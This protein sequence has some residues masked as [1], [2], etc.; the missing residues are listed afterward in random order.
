MKKLGEFVFLLA[1]C[2]LLALAGCS[3]S[4]SSHSAPTVSG[5][6]STGAAID[7]TVTLKDATGEEV[8]PQD[9]EPDGSFSFDVSGLTVPFVIKATATDGTQNWY[10]YASDSGTGNVNPLTTLVLAMAVD[11][12]DPADAYTDPSVV[13]DDKCD[14]ALDNAQALFADLFSGFGVG[15]DFDPFTGDCTVNH[16]GIDALFD[17]LDITVAD[18]SL[19]ITNKVDEIRLIDNTPIGDIDPDQP[20]KDVTDDLLWGTYNYC[21]LSFDTPTGGNGS[22]V[23]AGYLTFVADGTY[24][25]VEETSSSGE[26]GEENGEYVYQKKFSLDSGEEV[27]LT[28]DR[29]I[30]VV[31][32]KNAVEG[33]D[34]GFTIL[35][36]RDTSLTAADIS[37]DYLVMELGR[38]T[39]DGTAYAESG[40]VEVITFNGSGGYTGEEGSGTYTVDANTG[41]I[42]VDGGTLQGMVAKGGDVIVVSEIDSDSGGVGISVLV[43]TSSDP[44]WGV[45]S[46]N[47]EYWMA[48][49]YSAPEVTTA[50]GN[51]AVYAVRAALTME[52]GYIGGLFLYS[53]SKNDS[54]GPIP[55]IMSSSHPDVPKGLDYFLITEEEDM[56]EFLGI[57]SPDGEFFVMTNDVDTPEEAGISLGVKG[58]PLSA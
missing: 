39:T 13:S 44:D 14:S 24:T 48:E 23:G 11:S 25:A 8:G 41:R 32:D 6:A 17:A 53:T 19:A 21:Y 30:A 29:E 7:G 55:Y 47:G 4:S 35:C 15:E 26:T 3:D 5:I 43:K 9:I 12:G 34:V 20:L 49:L 57:V 22:D 28:P 56:Y 36:K 51:D 42:T 54:V 37:G 27:F 45:S 16:D 31:L 50:S 2:T 52:D 33:D 1:T 18:G 46:L 38:E 10:S 58:V 40:I